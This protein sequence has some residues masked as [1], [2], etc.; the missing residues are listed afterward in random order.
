MNSLLCAYLLHFMKIV[1]KVYEQKFE[2]VNCTN[3]LHFSHI[4]KLMAHERQLCHCCICDL[5]TGSAIS[6]HSCEF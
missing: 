5:G 3:N 1:H 2:T 6:L 4:Y